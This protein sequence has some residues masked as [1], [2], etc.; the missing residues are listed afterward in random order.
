MVQGAVYDAVNAIGP[1]RYEPYLLTKRFSPRASRSAAVA[2]AAHAV[3]ADIVSSVPNVED[4]PRATLLASLATQYEDFLD[5]IRDGRSK[6]AGIAAGSAAAEV[7]IRARQD[8]GRFGPSQWTP[9]RA[10]GHWWPL[11]DLV[12][13]QQLLDPTPWVGAVEPF[14]LESPSQFRTR[15]PK[16]L[17]S[18]GWARD[19]NEVKALGAADSRVRTEHQTYIARWWQSQPLASWNSVA[20]QLVTRRD[21]D[22]TTAA[23]LFALQNLS[24]ADASINCWND[25]YHYDFWRPW[26]AIP[27]A[28]EDGNAATR[29]RAGWAPL[30]SAPYPEHPSGH[31]CLDGASV[32]ILRAFFGNRIEHGYEIASASPL[33]QPTDERTRTFTSFRRVLVEVV[34]AR[35]WAGLHFRTAD[36]QG[37]VL[38]RKVADLAA[39]QY[40]QR[41]GHTR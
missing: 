26:N 6:A 4:A 35:I 27:R 36:V 33:L 15:G 5:E 24:T 23:R 17:T 29:P 8:D 19:F 37:R 31:L 7:M 11:N 39:E 20:R 10:P 32:R 14:V 38:G 22:A 18:A 28:A 9:N 2:T 30:I 1:R 34:E 41:T 3:L 21:L 25:K 13:G 40:L 12:S 16:A